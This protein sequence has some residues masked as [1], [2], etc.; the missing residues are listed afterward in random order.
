[1]GRATT[2]AAKESLRHKRSQPQLHSRPVAAH[3]AASRLKAVVFTEAGSMPAK[4][5]EPAR[6]AGV[7]LLDETAEKVA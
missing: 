2:S 1:L 4:D 6:I 3:S 7:L 5:D